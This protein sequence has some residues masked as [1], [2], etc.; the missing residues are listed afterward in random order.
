MDWIWDFFTDILNWIGLARKE[1]KLMFIGL[2]NAGK[3]T[4]LG[5]LRDGHL[6][7]NPPT[8]YPTCEELVVDKIKFTCHDLGGHLEARRIWPNY[9]PAVSGIVF[10]VDCADIERMEEAKKELNSILSHVYIKQIP[11]LVLGNK[12][13]SSR[14]LSEEQFRDALGLRSNITT[15]KKTPAKE[16]QKFQIRPIEV[17]MCSVI[18]RSGFREGFL[19]LSKYI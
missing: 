5:I 7:Q 12:I 1:G 14:A 8:M 16:I 10:L 13:D 17:F 18:Q 15:G 9:F 4:L 3:T 11:V 19:W 6:K 2:D